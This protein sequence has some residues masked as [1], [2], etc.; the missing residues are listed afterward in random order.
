MYFFLKHKVKHNPL[1]SAVSALLEPPLTHMPRKAHKGSTTTTSDGQFDLM[2]HTEGRKWAAIVLAHPKLGG[3]SYGDIEKK[4]KGAFSRAGLWRL[5]QKY[6]ATGN[7]ERAPRKKQPSLIGKDDILKLKLALMSADGG[8]QGQRKYRSLKKAH[9]R[10][11]AL[12]AVSACRETYRKALVKDK[13]AYQPVKRAL[14]LD[15]PDFEDRAK[16][17]RRECRIIAGNT[18]FTDSK[19]FPGEFSSKSRLGSAWAAQGD[20]PTQ[21]TKQKA[22]FQV[23]FYGGVTKHGATSLYLAKGTKGPSGRPRGRPPKS[24]AAAPIIPT[25]S[26]PA[27][28]AVDH[29]EYRRI[30]GSKVQHGL[31]K[32]GCALFGDVKWRF[33][34]D[35]ASAHSCKDTLIGKITRSVIE[36]CA[37]L[38]EPWP[39]KSAD[40]SPIEKA[41]YACEEHVWASETWSDL[42]TFTAAVRRSWQRKITPHYCAKLFRG[43]RPTYECVIAKGGRGIQ[44]WGRTAK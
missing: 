22:A 16:F 30:L 27:S 11:K 44:G 32:E 28:K 14:A 25:T 33:Q 3:L 43:I 13:W 10:L 2:T 17:A 35:G 42:N 19:V 12:G 37:S 18:M 21:K 4:L 5:Q 15:K 6:R 38:V 7:F 23:H 26:T 34:Q 36:E 24:A 29:V 41:W 9:P 20:P 40:M 1:L 39:A 31:L 8:E